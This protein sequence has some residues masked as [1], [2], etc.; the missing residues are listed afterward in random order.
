MQRVKN[1]HFLSNLKLVCLPEIR[2]FSYIRLHDESEFVCMREDCAFKYRRRRTDRYKDETYESLIKI[3]YMR[4]RVTTDDYYR[5]YRIE[6]HLGT[7]HFVPSHAILSIL[8]TIEQSERH[9]VFIKSYTIERELVSFSSARRKRKID[10]QSKLC[11]YV[12]S[13][14]S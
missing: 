12:L 14:S 4:C 8:R 10:C 3:I 7:S 11:L 6:T 5:Y 9:F 2:K 13:C 1:R